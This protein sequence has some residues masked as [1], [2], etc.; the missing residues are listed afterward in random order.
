MQLSLAPQNNAAGILCVLAGSFCFS[1]NDMGVKLLSGDYALHQL[2]MLRGLVAIA[3]ALAVFVPLDGGF[4]SLRTRRPGAHLL[5]GILIVFSN[6]C[7]FLAL[8]TM[9]LADTLAMFFIMPLLITALSVPLLGEKVGIRRWAAVAAG[10]AGVIVMLRPGGEAFRPEALLPLCAATAYAVTSIVTRRIGGTE[11]ASAM[12]VYIQLAFIVVSAALGLVVGDG[13]FAGQ[14][15]VTLDFL[16]RAWVVPPPADLAVVA[17]LGIASACGGWLIAQGYRICEAGL[18]APF[19]YVALPLA[20]LWGAT[21]FGDWPD[22]FAWIG[23]FLIV[24]SGLYMLWREA[25]RGRRLAS[26]SPAAGR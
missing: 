15:G 17:A 23:M 7:F 1:V 22:R 21:V 24:G 20:I 25:L 16:L 14:G 8:A 26:R 13:R 11:R 4:A 10:L 3:V 9:P 5:R 2:V 6:A 12:T 18:A 19:E